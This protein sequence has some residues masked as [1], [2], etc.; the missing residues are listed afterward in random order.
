MVIEQVDRRRLP[1]RP[2][3]VL[4][5]AAWRPAAGRF[6]AGFVVMNGSKIWPRIASVI[7]VPVSEIAKHTTS[8]SSRGR[9]VLVE[10]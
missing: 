3:H 1:R 2:P 6:P 7:P 9:R 4:D 10:P 5:P 8:S